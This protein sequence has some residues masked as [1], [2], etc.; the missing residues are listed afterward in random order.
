MKYFASSLGMTAE[1]YLSRYPEMATIP[2]WMFYEK[3]IDITAPQVTVNG[4]RITGLARE[5]K[6]GNG[7]R[8]TYPLKGSVVIR[9]KPLKLQFCTWTEMGEC[10][11][12]EKTAL[13]I[14][15]PIGIRGMGDNKLEIVDRNGFPVKGNV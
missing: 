14:K 1:E 11:F 6:N 9:E 13:D 3:T 15:M 5:E 7:R 12:G 8:V 4:K 10:L 2:D